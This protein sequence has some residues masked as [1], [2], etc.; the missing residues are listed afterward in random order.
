MDRRHKEIVE[1]ILTNHL[2][3]DVICIVLKYS[4]PVWSNKIELEKTIVTNPSSLKNYLS[5]LF[6]VNAFVET[7]WI[8]T[9]C[10]CLDIYD[11]KKSKLLQ[12]IYTSGRVEALCPLQS[13]KGFLVIT[14]Q[15][16]IGEGP[17]LHFYLKMWKFRQ[18]FSSE[19]KIANCGIY[20]AWDYY[21]ID[22]FCTR[23]LIIVGGNLGIEEIHIF[24]Y[25]I[26]LVATYLRKMSPS[27]IYSKPIFNYFLNSLIWSECNRN[28]KTTMVHVYNCECYKLMKD[29]TIN[30]D[31]SFIL[32]GVSNDGN[33]LIMMMDGDDYILQMI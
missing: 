28:G 3:R 26:D 5:T 20:S 30:L 14:G 33:L 29:L 1:Q 15:I 19:Y 4:R 8:K 7:R 32:K 13:E 18:D 21:D 16:E 31:C 17:F 22:V 9:D 11:S 10:T 12:T 25:K 6:D 24:N 23:D 2:Y 27:F